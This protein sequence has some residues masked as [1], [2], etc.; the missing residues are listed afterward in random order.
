MNLKSEKF[1]GPVNKLVN[2]LFSSKSNNSAVVGNDAQE[3]VK[4][5]QPEVKAKRAPR[6]YI[7]NVSCTTDRQ[8]ELLNSLKTQYR[9]GDGRKEA[10]ADALTSDEASNRKNFNLNKL[11]PIINDFLSFTLFETRDFMVSINHMFHEFNNNWALSEEVYCTITLFIALGSKDNSRFNLDPKLLARLAP[12]AKHHSCDE[13]GKT[14]NDLLDEI[15][16]KDPNLTQQIEK[17]RQIL[18]DGQQAQK[19]ERIQQMEKERQIFSDPKNVEN[20]EQALKA[21][22]QR[23]GITPA[24]TP[25]QSPE[26]QGMSMR[27]S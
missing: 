5:Q 9:E 12:Y 11:G 4:K 23:F 22:K 21:L 2:T 6:E 8:N 15:G 27:H 7:V 3:E 1:F 25:D 13:N 16:K 18:H 26:D 14:F 24:E 19:E 20:L 17:A 10:I